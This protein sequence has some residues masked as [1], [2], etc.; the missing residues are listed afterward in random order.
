MSNYYVPYSG[1][2]PAAAS[3]NG[4]KLLIMA[5]E[6]SVFDEENLG[7]L[8]ADR[9]K[10]VEVGET[11]D[12]QERRLSKMAKSVKAGLVIAPSEVS[13]ADVIKNLEAQLPW[14]Q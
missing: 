2:R 7:L 6:A 5:Q 14:I 13:V 9:V 12:E 10:K 4:H 11:K 3:I 1:N 8:G